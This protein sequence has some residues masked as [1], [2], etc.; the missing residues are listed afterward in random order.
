MSDFSLAGAQAICLYPEQYNA[1]ITALRQGNAFRPLGHAFGGDSKE[2]CCL[3]HCRS[4][5][6]SSC[7]LFFWVGNVLQL[8][9]AIINHGVLL[10]PLVHFAG[11]CRVGPGS[12]CPD[13]RET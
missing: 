6:H 11:C 2:K 1:A 8:V 3:R 9:L 5:G 7:A 12:P 10:L 4:P 13:I